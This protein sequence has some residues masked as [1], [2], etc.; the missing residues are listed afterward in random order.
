MIKIFFK[1][2]SGEK[3]NVGSNIVC[4]N[5]FLTKKILETFRKK[6]IN[7]GNKVKIKFVSDRPGHD[8][9]YALNSTKIKKKLKWKPKINLNQGILMT[10]EWYLNNQNYFNDI[11]KKL[12]VNRLGKND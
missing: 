7:I 11:S 5:I 9:R 6:K 10:I 12:F 8:F 4:N 2:K 1:G 3:Y